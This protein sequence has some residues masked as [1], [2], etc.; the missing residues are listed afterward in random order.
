MRK[1]PTYLKSEQIA[2]LKTFILTFILF[3]CASVFIIS[4]SD[5]DKPSIYLFCYAIKISLY[6]DRK[7]RFLDIPLTKQT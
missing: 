1:K 3:L 2:F 4:Y 6:I 7:F 5:P